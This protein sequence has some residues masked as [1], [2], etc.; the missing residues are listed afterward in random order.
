MSSNI[1]LFAGKNALSLIRHRGLEPDMVEVMAG[2]AGGPKW[3]I[4]YHLD[5][6]IFSSWITRRTSP[7][8]LIGSSIGAWRFAALSQKDPLNSLQNFKD[9]YIHQAYSKNPSPREV[10]GETIRIMNTFLNDSAI[11][12]ILN[13]PYLRLNF[14]A[15]YCKPIVSRDHCSILGPA[16]LAS[17]LLNF[18]DRRLLQL[19]YKRTLFYHSKSIPPFMNMNHFPLLKVPLDQNN[20]R[21]ALLATGSIP[22]V[23]SGVKNI[24]GATPGVY[25]DGGIIDYHLDIDFINRKDKIV[26]YPHFM[27]RIIPGWFD[28]RLPHRKPDPNRMA[29]VLMVSPSK[30]FVSKLPFGKISDRH[31]FVLF[32]GKDKERIAYWKKVIIM[33]KQ[34]AEDF[35]D[36]LESGRIR[37]LVKPLNR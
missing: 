23:M 22:L 6:F 24:S 13:H 16:I 12:E 10:T 36:V 19:F 25:R 4:L 17:A 32:K 8:F 2:A 35:H 1:E 7:L 11:H 9:A 29:S 34:L 21:D 3:L 14:M 5:R 37:H 27:D 18:I 20:I 33:G 28:K 26:L 15:V 30:N 31:D